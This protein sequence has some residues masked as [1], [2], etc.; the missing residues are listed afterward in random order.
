MN[1]KIQK[2]VDEHG[3][4]EEE[5]KCTLGAIATF[6]DA[7]AAFVT[8]GAN[9]TDIVKV[10]CEY[11]PDEST[12]RIKQ[13]FY[14]L[15]GQNYWGELLQELRDNYGFTET[16]VPPQVFPFNIYQKNPGCEPV[17]T[18]LLIQGYTIRDIASAISRFYERST[19]ATTIGKFITNGL[20]EALIMGQ[21]ASKIEGLI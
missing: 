6:Q 7:D 8:V 10:F 21:G 11:D 12:Y 17:L 15:S 4:S 1:S 5:V 13:K 2:L 3:F 14:P 20:E 18:S 16:G 9:S 19:F